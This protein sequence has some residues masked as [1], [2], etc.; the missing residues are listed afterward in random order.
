MRD[1]SPQRSDQPHKTDP[2]IIETASADGSLRRPVT[3]RTRCGIPSSGARCRPFVPNVG[4]FPRPSGRRRRGAE[5]RLR[6]DK[7]F[8][9]ISLVML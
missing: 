7:R 8:P 2:A 1:R 5:A 6:I 4:P 9:Q 3:A